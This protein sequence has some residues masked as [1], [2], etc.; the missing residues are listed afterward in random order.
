MKKRLFLPFIDNGMGLSRTSW[1]L[2]MF[3]LGLSSV[4]EGWEVMAQGISYPYPDGAMNIAT[5]DFLESGSD[6]MLIIDTDEI[7]NP[8]AIARLLAHDLDFVSG[9]YPKKVPGLEWPI[10]P[11]PE[12]P[13]PF[14]AGQ[15]V[16]VE[17]A[18]CPRGLLSLSRNVFDALEHQVPAYT[19]SETG[20]QQ[21]LY[22]QPLL[23]GHS[24][25]FYLCDLWRSIGGKV[26]VD[27][28]VQARHEGSCVYPIPGTY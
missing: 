7:F 10:V 25:D 24:E 28:T 8:G 5:A 14:A 18:R 27:P 23:G 6:R 15:P 22:W 17:V 11:L 12:N 19:D 4:L 26:W 9:I 20:R 1:A 21:R 3:S 13:T 16:P 2:S